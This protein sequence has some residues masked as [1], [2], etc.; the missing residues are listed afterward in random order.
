[1]TYTFNI[2]KGFVQQLHTFSRVLF[3]GGSGEECFIMIFVGFPAFNAD[4][5]LKSGVILPEGLLYPFEV[6]LTVAGLGMGESRN[7]GCG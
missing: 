5:V 3:G 6:G 1:M 7:E 2:S 4:G